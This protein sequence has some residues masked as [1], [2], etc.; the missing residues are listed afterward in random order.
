M[1]RAIVLLLA[2]GLGGCLPD[3]AKDMAGCQTEVE[4][5]YPTYEAIHPDD[6]SSRYIIECMAAKGYDFTVMP[7]DCNSSRSL[8]TQPEC[9]QS[10]NWATRMLDRFSR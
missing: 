4:R 5:F 8:P 10:Q 2:I 3:R 9:Y 1:K 6:P 7:S